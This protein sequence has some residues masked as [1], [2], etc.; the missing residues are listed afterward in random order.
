LDPHDDGAFVNRGIAYR[1]LGDLERAIKDYDEAIRL[2]PPSITAAMHFERAR[3]SSGPCA[4]T[5]RRF[6]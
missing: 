1:R 4:I 2:N 6:G 3:S 5:M